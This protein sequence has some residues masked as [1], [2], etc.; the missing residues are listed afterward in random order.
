MEAARAAGEGRALTV[1]RYTPGVGWLPA[2]DG[3]LSTFCEAAVPV[4][5]CHR[6]READAAPRCARE[7]VCR[8]SAERKFQ[9]APDRSL[10]VRRHPFVAYPE[11]LRLGPLQPRVWSR[12]KSSL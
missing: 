10:R 1:F 9:I 2:V 12:H 3:D 6:N 4:Q 11:L 8:E 7:R 5:G